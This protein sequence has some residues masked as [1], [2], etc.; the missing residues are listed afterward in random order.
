LLVGETALF[1]H[2]IDTAV[3]V[4]VE[5]NLHERSM[6]SRRAVARAFSK[7]NGVARSAPR[8]RQPTG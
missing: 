7:A 4:E 5:T 2:G 6:L 3:R 8:P 1:E